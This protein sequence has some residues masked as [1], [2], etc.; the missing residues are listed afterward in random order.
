MCFEPTQ[1]PQQTR[2]GPAN[3]CLF[4]REGNQ[5][6]GVAVRSVGG[7]SVRMRAPWAKRF[8]SPTAVG[9]LFP[10][11]VLQNYLPF[12]WRQHVLQ[13]RGCPEQ[14]QPVVEWLALLRVAQVRNEFCDIFANRGSS[15]VVSGSDAGGQRRQR[16]PVERGVRSLPG[17]KVEVRPVP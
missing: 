14:D 2:I 1:R 13:L 9:L 8:Q 12:G 10:P 4:Q 6:G 5:P 7:W 11:D 17:I 15:L 16:G 3:S